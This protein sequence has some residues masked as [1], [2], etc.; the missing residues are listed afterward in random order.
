MV[1]ERK[2][3][4]PDADLQRQIQAVPV[5]PD[6]PVNLPP[7]FNRYEM[8]DVIV[9][10]RGLARYINLNPTIV[11][12]NDAKFANRP[13]GKAKISIV[14][15]LIN[16]MMRSGKFTG[17]KSKAYNVVKEAFNILEQRTKENPVQVFIRAVES[18]APRED[19]TRLVFG[20]ISVPKAVDISP[21]RRLDIA[22]RNICKGAM[23]S[24]RKNR[25]SISECL[26]DEILLAS[27]GD[28]N[29]FAVGRK[30]EMER[31]AAS[32]R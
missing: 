21:S 18:S 31:V 19:T 26:A 30:D 4:R 28:G 15:R 23:N 10:D 27:K 8:K 13:F 24:S 16:G 29:S 22:V 12:Y 32:A 3:S 14:E 25:K 17:K 2:E 7:L 11:P 6:L 9:K 20:G 5:A 1:E